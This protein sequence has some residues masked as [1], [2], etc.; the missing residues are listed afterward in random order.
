MYFKKRIVSLEKRFTTP[1]VN[2]YQ[3]EK[4]QLQ[5]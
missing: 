5:S 2:I 1:L 4:Y 3:A